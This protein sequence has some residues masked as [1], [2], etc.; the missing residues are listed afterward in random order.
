MIKY[1]WISG[2]HHIFMTDW[3]ENFCWPGGRPRWWGRCSRRWRSPTTLPLLW[4]SS[5]TDTR[6]HY[7]TLVYYFQK[8][9]VVIK[10]VSIELTI[11]VSLAERSKLIMSQIIQSTSLNSDGVGALLTLI[12]HWKSFYPF[13]TAMGPR[14]IIPLFTLS[15]SLII[16][17]Y[18]C[19]LYFRSV[20]SVLC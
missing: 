9:R 20:E 7:W 18:G 19:A 17:H 11:I 15:N 1:S 12:A 10:W 16:H 13:L 2:L 3:A 5:W 8:C 4:S 6:E 14:L